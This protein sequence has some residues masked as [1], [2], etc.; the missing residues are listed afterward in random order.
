M[1]ITIEQIAR[2]ICKNTTLSCGSKIDYDTIPYHK[3]LTFISQAK[4]FVEVF[5]NL[6][7]KNV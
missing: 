6:N 5:K 4:L 7:K 2:E 1:K 3:K